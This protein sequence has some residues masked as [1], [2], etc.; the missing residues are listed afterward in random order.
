MQLNLNKDTLFK[1]LLVLIMT[2]ILDIC[3]IRLDFITGNFAQPVAATGQCATRDT[4][5]VTPGGGEAIPV[6]CGDI[7]TQHSK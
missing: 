2:L 7:S 6:V 5:T 3:Q 1:I 4:V